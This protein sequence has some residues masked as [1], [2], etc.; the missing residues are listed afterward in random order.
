MSSMPALDPKTYAAVVTVRINDGV[1]LPEDTSASI[2]SEGLLGGNYVGLSPGG[3]ETMLA[4]GQSFQVTQSA[5]N[6]ESLLGQFI[7]NMGKSGGS[8]KLR[9][10]RPERCGGG[11]CPQR[12][13]VE[14]GQPVRGS[15]QQIMRALA[16]FSVIALALSVGGALA[17]SADGSDGSA[18]VPPA[19]AVPAG[20]GNC[21][22]PAQHVQPIP[23]PALP[24]PPGLVPATPPAD[25]DTGGSASTGQ[26]TPDGSAAS[27]Q[28]ATSAPTPTTPT[29]PAAP[30]QDIAPIPPNT[31]LPAKT[32]EIGVL[33]KV[34]GSVSTISI[35]VGG[36][37]VVGDLQVNVQACMIRPPDQVPDAAVFLA[38]QST[39][40]PS[41]P[42]NYRGWL[43]KSAPGA[44]VAGDA[45]ETFR[46][47]DCS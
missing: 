30:V 36:Q 20:T 35:P 5:I 43:V 44:A 31:W 7:F 22:R 25:I 39:Q 32:A 9:P 4:P 15:W 2:S 29:T 34:D 17:Q 10:E 1:K 40:D 26:N 45:S 37:S 12:R 38:L 27:G 11:C 33:D 28:A 41:A 16:A 21:R 6:L 23:A 47:I 3:S 42:P 14:P 13:R 24:P 18:A 19:I 46:V 8:A